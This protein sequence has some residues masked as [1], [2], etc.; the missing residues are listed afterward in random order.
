ML[1]QIKK[2]IERGRL[3]NRLLLLIFHIFTFILQQVKLNF[4]N[5]YSFNF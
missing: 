1:G 5:P 4:W 2:N 3:F